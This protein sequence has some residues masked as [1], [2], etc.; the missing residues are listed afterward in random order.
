MLRVTYSDQVCKSSAQEL[1]GESILE[2]RFPELLRDMVTDCL[3]ATQRHY[4][5]MYYRDGKTVAEI[6]NV[7]GV[8]KSTV[9]R[10]VNRAK[11]KLMKAF[12]AELGSRVL[13]GQ[14]RLQQL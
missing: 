4:L 2:Q 6:A 12:E 11:Q 9:S 7:C 5:L 10:T 3:T 13:S 1:Q 14:C 8:N